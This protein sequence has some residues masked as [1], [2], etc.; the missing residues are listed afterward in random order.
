MQV[1]DRMPEAFFLIK[2]IVCEKCTS[3]DLNHDT[4]GCQACTWCYNVGH[5]IDKCKDKCPELKKTQTIHYIVVFEIREDQNKMVNHDIAS[6]LLEDKFKD[7]KPQIRY[8]KDKK[9][10]LFELSGEFEQTESAYKEILK[11]IDDLNQHYVYYAE[12]VIPEVTYVNPYNKPQKNGMEIV[13]PYKTAPV[14]IEIQ[15]TKFLPN[16]CII[17]KVK[18]SLFMDPNFGRLLRDVRNNKEK[19]QYKYGQ[20]VGVFKLVYLKS[21]NPTS[22]EEFG[23]KFSNLDDV[24]IISTDH[25]DLCLGVDHRRTNCA[26][27]CYYSS[28]EGHMIN[29][30]SIFNYEAGQVKGCVEHKGRPPP[31]TN[32]P[33][34][35]STNKN[36]LKKLSASWRKPINKIEYF[37]ILE[38]EEFDRDNIEQELEVNE[39]KKVIFMSMDSKHCPVIDNENNIAYEV[40]V[41]ATTKKGQQEINGIYKAYVNLY[42]TCCRWDDQYFHCSLPMLRYGQPLTKVRHDLEQIFSKQ[43]SICMNRHNSIA[44]CLFNELIFRVILCKYSIF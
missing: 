7:I 6:K 25:C 43:R 41:T 23:R 18:S 27:R 9:A 3:F 21:K 42:D 19:I 22:L 35:A 38:Q 15:T 2:D 13:T 11:A 28:G 39:H 44:V 4:F 10:H 31:T 30:C 12:N 34:K 36:T 29:D 17:L 5:E 8:S 1:Q 26:N 32:K 40:V 14:P 16:D 20:K 33:K 37:N 24:S